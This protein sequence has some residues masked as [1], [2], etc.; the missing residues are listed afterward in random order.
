VL[1]LRNSPS[2]CCGGAVDSASTAL[3]ASSAALPQC[4]LPYSVALKEKDFCEAL[5][6]PLTA[7]LLRGYDYA[8]LYSWLVCKG[9]GLPA[10]C[11]S[12][13]VLAIVALTVK[14]IEIAACDFASISPQ[15]LAVAPATLQLRPGE[16]AGFDVQVTMAARKQFANTPQV[17]VS[18]VVDLLTEE[19]PFDKQA[20]AKMAD[21]I[22]GTSLEGAKLS[23]QPSCVT[24]VPSD[25]AS[26]TLQPKLAG[27]S[28]DGRVVSA[29]QDATPGTAANLAPSNPLGLATTDGRVRVCFTTESCS[30]PA[31]STVRYAYTPYPQG[32]GLRTE[33]SVLTEIT[34]HGANTVAFWQFL[35]S[36][37]S[38]TV[39]TGGQY[40]IWED[41]LAINGAHRDPYLKCNGQWDFQG[42]F[43]A[44]PCAG[45]QGTAN[46]HRKQWSPSR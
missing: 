4:L 7:A 8:L 17:L 40:A 33:N 21:A 44:V 32:R 29:S 36:S 24:S 41:A 27:L 31:G 20:I 10:A 37:T 13:A 14:L 15:S 16:T 39:T 12:A 43:S 23:P 11:E 3:K 9:S 18:E 34:C 45:C 35:N 30:P 19:A 22:I 25:L 1:R 42:A 46:T 5:E 6:G 2:A 26:V 28:I 38:Q